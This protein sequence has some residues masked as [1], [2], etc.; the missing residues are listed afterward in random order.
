MFLS[1]RDNIEDPLDDLGTVVQQL[2]QVNEMIKITLGHGF[3][4]NFLIYTN[5]VSCNA[6]EC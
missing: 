5:A 1:F 3:A 4:R 6:N 2:E